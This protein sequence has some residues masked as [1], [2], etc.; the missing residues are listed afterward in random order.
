[1]L[2]RNQTNISTVEILANESLKLRFPDPTIDPRVPDII[3]IGNLGT[4]YSA[5]TG[6]VAEHGGFSD[7]DVNVPIVI[8][9]PSLAAQTIKTPVQTTQIA[10][11]ILQLLGLNPFAL[12]A[13]QMEHTTVLPGF[14]AAFATIDGRIVNRLQFSTNS[15]IELRNGQSEFAVSG[16]RTQSFTVQASSD[17]TNWT[18]ILTNSLV[19]GGSKTIKDTQ[20][21]GLTNR[22]YRTIQAL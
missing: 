13:V 7:Q 12:Q 22:F 2:L 16:V 5:S 4:I 11:T 17:L 6:K 1:V 8:S 20:A 3:A 14:D 18:N 21:P 15:V 19:V 9:N 10:P